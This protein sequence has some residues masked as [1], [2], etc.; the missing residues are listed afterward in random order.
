MSYSGDGQIPG[1]NLL[2]TSIFV[3]GTKSI[4]G[5]ELGN[6]PYRMADSLQGTYD[7]GDD[8]QFVMYPRSLGPATGFGDPTYDV[9]EGLATQQVVDLVKAAKTADPDKKIYVVGY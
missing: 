2:A 6:P 1:A 9:S 8:N 7:N 4:T 3:D 5:N